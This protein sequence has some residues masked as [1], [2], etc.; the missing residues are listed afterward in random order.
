[1]LSDFAPVPYAALP[2]RSILVASSND[3]LPPHPPQLAAPRARLGQQVC[4]SA[5]RRG[6]NVDSDR[7]GRWPLGER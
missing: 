4:A 2:Y 6:I 7:A 3:P 5:K 1:M